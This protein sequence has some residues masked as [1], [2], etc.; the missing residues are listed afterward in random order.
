MVTETSTVLC[1]VRVLD[2]TRFVSGSYAGQ[3][4]AGLGADVL[5][6]EVPPGGDPY[7]DQGTVRVGDESVLFMALNSGKKS[8]AIDFRSP[9]AFE[10]IE[11]LLASADVLIENARPGTMKRYGLDYE[12]IH[13]RHPL[14]IYG[15]ISGFGDVGPDAQRGGFDLILQAESGLMSV[16]GHPESGPAKVGAP[17]TDVGAGLTCVAGITAALFERTRT[18]VGRHIS[19]SLLEF[20]L[21][22]LS[23]LATPTFLAADLPGLLGTH[24]PTFAPY[25]AFRASDGWF[26][27]AGAGS[28]ELWVRLCLALD[29]EDLL[30]DTRFIDN[31]SRV[32]NRKTLSAEIESTTGSK[33]VSHW[34]D[35]LGGQGVPCAR[36]ANLEEAF[37]SRQVDALDMVESVTTASGESF[38]TVAVP[39]RVDGHRPGGPRTAPRLGEHTREILLGLGTSET[40]LAELVSKGIAAV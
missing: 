24:S 34:L 9:E 3:L 1:G 2:F 7:R 4:L 21:S 31:A 20:A 28:E 35:L 32:D 19:T 16:T 10:H 27:L 33:S 23:T 39:I 15:S 25:G 12:S 11:R 14:M 36:V 30:T 37:A 38:A 26:V 29:R 13:V 5:K 6:I 22:S 17:V 18:G 8:V 40:D